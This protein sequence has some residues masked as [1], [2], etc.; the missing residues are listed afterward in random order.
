MSHKAG[1]VKVWIAELKDRPGSVSGK[2]A[3]LAKAGANLEFIL[4]RRQPERPGKGVLFVS[5][6]KGARQEEAARDCGFIEARTLS[7]VRVEGTNRT[8][9]GHRMTGAVAD[10]GINLRGLAASVY[11]RKFIAFFVFDTAKDARRGLQTLKRV[12]KA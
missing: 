9:L 7:T 10:A 4:A 1:M 5:P 6:L 12:K 11:G 3:A 2:L 8:G